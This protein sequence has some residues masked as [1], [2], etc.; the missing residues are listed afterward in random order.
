MP[1]FDRRFPIR[2]E[3]PVAALDARSDETHRRRPS[4]TE[5]PVAFAGGAFKMAR[6]I[7]RQ[8]AAMPPPSDPQHSDPAPFTAAERHLI[9]A[10]FRARSG[11]TYP[12]DD[13]IWLHRWAAGPHQGQPKLSRTAIRTL[14]ERGL[15]EIVDPP[16]R[17][18]F[19]RFTRAGLN[20]LRHL[21]R[22]RRSLPP[23]QYAHLL[24]ELDAKLGPA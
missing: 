22:D 12:L 1:R 7:S 13:G 9:R 6:S 18:P 2:F 21:A 17:L 24:A 10:E 4:D 19:A 14:L 8:R 23:D 3:K 16:G 5:K 20:A 11:Q 15:I